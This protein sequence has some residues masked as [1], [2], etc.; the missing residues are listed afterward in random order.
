MRKILFPILVAF[1]GNLY[2]GVEIELTFDQN[3]L[4]LSTDGIYTKVFYQNADIIQT[5]S[6][7]QLPL[8]VVPVLLPPGEKAKSV[9]Y[10]II[11]KSELPGQ[12]TVYPAQKPQIKPIPGISVPLPHFEQPNKRIYSQARAYPLSAVKLCS[13]GFARGYSIAGIIVYPVIYYPARGKLELITSLKI[14]ITTERSSS[15]FPERQSEIAKE[16]ME[17]IISKLVVNPDLLPLYEN[18]MRVDENGYDYLLITRER[19]RDFWRPYMQM[20]NEEGLRD[21]IVTFEEIA[22]TMPGRDNAEKVRAYLRYA[23]ENLGILY[24]LL[25]GDTETIPARVAFAMNCEAGFFA[26][27]NDIR[28]DYYFACLDG[29][30]DYNLNNIFGEPGDSVDLYPELIVGRAPV[31]NRED[32]ITFINKNSTY[33]ASPRESYLTDALFTGEILWDDPYTDSGIGKD[34]VGRIFPPH[35]NI[36]RLYESYGNENLTNVVASLNEGKGIFNH[37]GHGFINLMGVGNEEYLESYAV[38]GLTNGQMQ[39]IVFSIGCWCGAFDYDCIGEEF[40]RASSGGAIAFI[41]NSRYGWGSP[42]NPGYGYSDKYDFWYFKSIFSPG[43][44]RLGSALSFVKL[45]YAPLSQ[46]ANLYRWH[47]YQV[48]LIGDPSVTLWRSEPKTMALLHSASL[49]VSATGINILAKDESGEPIQGAIITLIQNSKIISRGITDL[50]GIARLRFE[51]ALLPGQAHIFGWKPDYRKVDNIVVVNSTGYTLRLEEYS[52]VDEHGDVH[53]STI[54]AGSTDTLRFKIINDGSEVSPGIEIILREPSGAVFIRDTIFSLPFLE[55]S[56]T[57]SF[58]TVI[59]VPSGSRNPIRIDIQIVAGSETTDD[60]ITLVPLYPDLVATDYIVVGS[61][62]PNILEPGELAHIRFLFKNTGGYRADETWADINPLSELLVFGSLSV[63][64]PGAEPGETVASNEV[65]LA[66]SPEIP[67]GSIVPV[68]VRTSS[69]TPDTI[70]FEIG[71]FAFFDNAETESGMSHLGIRD[72]WARSDVRAHSGRFSWAFTTESGYPPNSNATLMTPE[73][74]APK[75]GILSFWYYFNVANYGNDGLYVKV[76]GERGDT[77]TLDYFGSG[78]ALLPILNFSVGWAQAYY[79]LPGSPGERIRV[80]F[81]VVTDTSNTGEGFYI[82]DVKIFRPRESA[83]SIEQDETKTPARFSLS[84]FPNPANNI[85]NIHYSTSE[86]ATIRIFNLLGRC[87]VTYSLEKGE[88]KREFGNDLPSGIY[89][90][91]L[92][93]LNRTIVKRAVLLK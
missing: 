61:G 21:T 7:P 8:L 67:D 70:Y 73:I 82:D 54:V 87:V 75:N 11:S 71:Q 28:A 51:R 25:G 57:A 88:G 92:D 24:L 85:L 32:I 36:E 1:L 14:N 40:V 22:G 49:T 86:Q 53:D 19:F 50:L 30:W 62:S 64:L 43:I 20:L 2:G 72:V 65:E 3:K 52:I 58:A 34:M 17:R 78:G 38:A 39:G 29:D 18:L 93:A 63:Y 9:E 91:R 81:Q 59:S 55:P 6:E 66:I 13:S 33:R 23:Y 12:F 68:V 4:I 79:R 83:T 89:F 74:F 60:R 76:V 69:P 44:P 77:T 46:S 48:N 5:P 45:Y 16:E 10:E 56:G 35:F 47:E 26:D 41:G 37:D 15:I 90:V 42:G 80:L 27:E 84:V 31:R